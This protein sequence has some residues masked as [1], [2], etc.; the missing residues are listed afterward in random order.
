MGRTKSNF[1]NFLAEEGKW[2]RC[3]RRRSKKKDLFRVNTMTRLIYFTNND[4]FARYIYDGVALF[5]IDI[6]LEFEK[7]HLF[8]HRH[9]FYEKCVWSSVNRDDLSSSKG[10]K[11]EHAPKFALTN[12]VFARLTVS[13]RLSCLFR[14]LLDETAVYSFGFTSTLTGCLCHSLDS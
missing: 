4:V 1:E 2:R 5:S 3:E 8:Y 12:D 13:P 10:W 6:D 14:F 11:S 9:T 7:L